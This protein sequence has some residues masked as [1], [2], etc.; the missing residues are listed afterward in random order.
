MPIARFSLNADGSLLAT[1]SEKVRHQCFF[2]FF[3]LVRMRGECA[4]VAPLLLFLSQR[5]HTQTRRRLDVV[6]AG[7][8]RR[9]P[10]SACGTRGSGKSAPN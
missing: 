3:C 6:V 1:V 2:L 9:A 8:A 5:R 10:S 4:F 7:G